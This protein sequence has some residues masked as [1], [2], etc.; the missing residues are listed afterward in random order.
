MTEPRDI[1]VVIDEMLDHIDYVEAR[2][3]DLGL[4]EFRQ[5]R[6]IRQ[7]VE[8]SLEIVSEASRRLP[9]ELKDARPEIPWRQVADFG[10]V[11]RHAYFAVNEEI[12]WSIIK[13]ELPGL[14]DAL[15]ALRRKLVD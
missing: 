10:N 1:R 7:S 15:R 12:V 11:L 5:S 9:A 4:A 13:V 2:T 14:G 8:R 6:D 3:S